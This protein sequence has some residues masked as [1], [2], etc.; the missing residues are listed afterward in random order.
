MDFLKSKAD[1]SN[2]ALVQ[3][4]CALW[5]LCHG[6]GK[7]I[8]ALNEDDEFFAHWSMVIDKCISED[9]FLLAT[10]ALGAGAAAFGFSPD[11]RKNI[12]DE[13]LLPKISVIL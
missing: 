13:K 4:Y 9:N 11:R 3:R 12:M 6:N 2:Q 5:A 10:M 7:N 8:G 1:P